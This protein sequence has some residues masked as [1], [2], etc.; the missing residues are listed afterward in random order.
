MAHSLEPIIQSGVWV[1]VWV[2]VEHLAQAQADWVFEGSQ[3]LPVEAFRS[4]LDEAEW[5]DER[6]WRP[7]NCPTSLAPNSR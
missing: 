7:W 4:L 6:L 2:W 1:W 5:E 3:A